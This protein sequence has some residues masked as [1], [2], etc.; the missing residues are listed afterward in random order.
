MA[1]GGLDLPHEG[2]L[3][4][5]EP[6]LPLG[7]TPQAVMGAK[8]RDQE[9]RSGQAKKARGTGQTQDTRESSRPQAM[10]PALP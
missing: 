6:G 5:G 1:P 8:E 4:P 7:P 10:A 2:K 9:E 3:R